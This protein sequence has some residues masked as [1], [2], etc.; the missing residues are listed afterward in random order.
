MCAKNLLQTTVVIVMLATLTGG[1]FSP[2]SAASISQ[3]IPD[4]AATARLPGAFAFHGTSLSQPPQA[5]R[6]ANFAAVVAGEFHTCALTT[7]GAVW[8]WGDNPYGQLGDGTTTQRM[9]PVAVKLEADIVAIAAGADH[10]C[11][12]TTGGAVTCWGGNWDGQLGDGTTSN[13]LDPVAVSG[14]GSGVAA[15]AAGGD[16]TCALTTAG[17]VMCWGTNYDGQLGDGTTDERP[18]PVAVQG[19]ES[20]VVAIAAGLMHTCALTTS[21]AAKCW[22][23]NY[24]GQLGDGTIDTR[25]TPAAV[26]GLGGGAAAIAAGGYHTCALLDG[27]AAR[28][29]GGNRDGQ[30]GDGT[31]DDRLTPTPVSGLSSGV[32]AIA[33]GAYHTCA[34][35]NG[36]AVRCWGSNQY[37][38]LGDA[39]TGDRL[40]TPAAVRGL[41][42]GV[43]AI[44][45]G[46]DHTCVL[47]TG[48][49]VKCWGSNEYGQLGNRLGLPVG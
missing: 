6:P 49:A 46:D 33:A 31:T 3:P 35:L 27:G 34:L 43:A 39:T 18:T 4:L 14:L 11:A 48:G 26:S 1:R 23:T 28:C 36:G 5:S 2:V 16:H 37:G 13:H 44:A 29:W 40:L 21:G 22:G 25:L 32:A 8:C 47:T 10:T 30:L 7:G 15:I 20:G 41:G 19:L 24:T 38:Q 45:A 17:A 12:L 42:S 9:T